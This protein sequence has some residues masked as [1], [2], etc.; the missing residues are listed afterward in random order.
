MSLSDDWLQVLASPAALRLGSETVPAS[1]I[2]FVAVTQLERLLV[3]VVF[4]EKSGRRYPPALIFL[5][6]N[7]FRGVR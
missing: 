2:L 5:S 7:V 1:A 4:R 6:Y 3:I